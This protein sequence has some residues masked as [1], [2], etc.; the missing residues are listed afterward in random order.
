MKVCVVGLGAIGGT[1]GYYLARAGCELSALARGKTLAALAQKGLRLIEEKAGQEIE[2]SVSIRASGDPSCLGPQDLVVLA[3]KAPALGALA[4]ALK[5]LLKADTIVM[6]AMNGIPWW[7]FQ[8]FGAALKGRRLRS[9]DPDGLISSSIPRKSILGCV[10]HLGAVCPEPGLVKPLP[11]KTLILGEPSGTSSARLTALAG[12]FTRAGFDVKISHSIQNDIWYKLWGN[13]TMNPI[14]ALTGATMDRILDDPLVEA[15]C[16]QIMT[17]AEHVGERIGCKIEQS[18]E[19]R[20]AVSRTLGAFKTSMLQDA[21]AGKPL[22]LDAL[23]GAVAEIG[24]LLGLQT[25]A[26]DILLGLTRLRARV[27]GLYPEEA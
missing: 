15:F 13:M 5:P 26:I 24:D 14:S 27:E 25:P 12:L 3:V 1:L 8:D 21:E 10:V 23:V 16:R 7:F 4:S 20:L 6:P 22:E 11:L 2:G 9:V 18:V 19:D 17:E